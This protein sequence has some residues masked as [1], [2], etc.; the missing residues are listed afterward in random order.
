MIPDEIL[1]VAPRVLSQSDRERFF[2]TGYLCIN[3]LVPAAQVQGLLEVTESFVDQSRAVTASND[4]FDV[5]PEHTADQ[6]RMRR[7][8]SPDIQ[9]EA[10]WALATGILADVAADLVGP[11]VV[12]HHSKLNFKW[13]DETDEVKWHQDAQFFPHTNYNVLT[14]GTYL[15]DTGP[16][17]GPLAVIPRSHDGPLYDQYDTADG[18]VG[19]L[20]SD[21]VS[22]LDLE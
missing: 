20:S 13:Y 15:T 5:A 22:S 7:L 12:F 18:W 11:H 6:P 21:D 3:D 10:Y 16:D 1:K 4:T 8:K 17:D 2:A 9:H 19:H 14:I